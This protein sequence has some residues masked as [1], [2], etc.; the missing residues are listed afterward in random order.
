MKNFLEKLWDDYKSEETITPTKEEFYLREK[1]CDIKSSLRESICDDSFE[2][3]ENLENVI[4]D[5]ER[6]Y[7]K[8]AFT[9]GVKFALKLL[10]S[11]LTE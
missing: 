2:L 6:S 8:L 11:A 4:F 10:F 1:L 5:I 9:E 3:V 7:I